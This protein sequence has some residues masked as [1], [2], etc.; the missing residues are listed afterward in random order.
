MMELGRFAKKLH[1][2][3]L[4]PILS[5]KPDIVITLGNFTKVIHEDLPEK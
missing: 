3:T 2:N 1:K 5:A 4:K